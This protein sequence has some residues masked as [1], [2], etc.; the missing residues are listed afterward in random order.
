MPSKR[1]NRNTNG[2]FPRNWVLFVDHPFQYISVR[3]E[4]GS[5]QE[6]C[7][8]MWFGREWLGELMGVTD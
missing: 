5:L 2:G 4:T 7:L 3:F 1:M 8:L 6:I